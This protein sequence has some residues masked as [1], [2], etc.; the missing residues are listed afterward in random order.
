MA[1]P[2]AD[3]YGIGALE[4]GQ[5]LVIPG[6]S[7]A[8]VSSTIVRFRAQGRDYMTKKIDEGCFVYRYK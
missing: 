6:K 1:T 2:G 3:K 5:T 8:Q 4:P 7:P